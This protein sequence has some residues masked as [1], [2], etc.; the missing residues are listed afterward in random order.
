M[1]T[2]RASKMREVAS[3]PSVA[4]SASNWFAR[5]SR[6]VRAAACAS[7]CRDGSVVSSLHCPDNL[8]HHPAIGLSGRSVAGNKDRENISNWDG[9]CRFTI[10]RGGKISKLITVRCTGRVPKLPV[11]GLPP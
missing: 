5:S 9:Q 3:M 10:L 2:L 1:R 6:K 4:S 11:G 8:A 7:S